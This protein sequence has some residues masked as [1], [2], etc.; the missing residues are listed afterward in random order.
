MNTTTDFCLTQLEN[1]SACLEKY[2]EFTPNPCKKAERFHRSLENDRTIEI[3]QHIC[4][5]QQQ[6][7][8]IWAGLKAV[9][10][11]F[12]TQFRKARKAEAQCDTFGSST[13]L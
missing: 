5:Q 3:E 1:D 9:G 4:S 12:V 11:W 8:L 7:E 6:R 10:A 13:A 2:V